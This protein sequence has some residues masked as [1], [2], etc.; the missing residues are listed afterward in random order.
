V[1]NRNSLKL[2]PNY[3]YRNP[4][5]LQLLG[6]FVPQTPYRGFAPGPHWGTSVPQTPCT[7]RPLTFCTRFTPLIASNCGL[8]FPNSPIDRIINLFWK[9]SGGGGLGRTV[10]DGKQI[11]VGLG[12]AHQAPLRAI[13]GYAPVP[14]TVYLRSLT[15]ISVLVEN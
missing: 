2:G 9:G 5:L 14:S 7:G 12:P 1:Q 15:F 6:D 11:G 10:G 8:E 4:K 3:A 13:S